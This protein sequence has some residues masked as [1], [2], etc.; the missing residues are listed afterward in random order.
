MARGLAT[1]FRPRKPCSRSYVEGISSVLNR[2]NVLLSAGATFALAGASAAGAA[3]PAEAQLSKLLDEVFA[4][5]LTDNP[6][7]VTSLGL[8]KAERAAAKSQLH[9]ASLAGVE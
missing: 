4:E 3:T 8:D 2:R 7:L 6:E 1:S 9:D 5:T